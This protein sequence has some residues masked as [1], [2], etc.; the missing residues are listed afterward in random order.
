MNNGKIPS[1]IRWTRSDY[2]KLSYA[3]RQF[4][5]KVNELESMEKIY[6]PEEFTYNE[7]KEGIYSRKELN[8]VIKSLKRFS[9]E[10]Q[11]RIVTTDGGVKLTQWELSELKKAQK[12]SSARLVDSA[13]AIV[14]S[15][16]NVMGDREFKQLVRTRESIEDLFNRV[17]SD[18]KTTKKRALIW[19]KTDYEL[20]RADVFRSNFM[21]A[22]EYMS[23]YNN[24]DI[25]YQKL[26]SIKNPIQFYNYINQSDTLKDIFLYYRDENT[27]NTYGGFK[28]NQNAFNKALDDLNL[29]NINELDT[30]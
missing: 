9:K 29:L 13:R 30:E 25:L 6:A 1:M 5:K 28:S 26:N 19:G 16:V 4:N 27:A 22:L 20:W 23:N 8:R 7:L 18:F 2:A 14:Q 21:N 3:V 11:Q 24:Y 12:R 15:D 10:S 17:G